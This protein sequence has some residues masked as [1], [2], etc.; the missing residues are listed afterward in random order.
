M[1]KRRTTKK[2]N[3]YVLRGF[4]S[5]MPHEK[6]ASALQKAGIPLPAGELSYATVKI[7]T[8]DWYV[9]ADDEWYWW[10][11]KEWKLLPNG[12]LWR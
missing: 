2:Q 7:G 5:R 4:G 6:V 8:T 3:D 11:G 12:P 1:K 10:S 9:V